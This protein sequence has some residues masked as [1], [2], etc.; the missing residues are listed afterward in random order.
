MMRFGMFLVMVSGNAAY[1]PANWR[2][3][4]ESPC[5]SRGSIWRLAIIYIVSIDLYIKYWVDD[6]HPGHLSNFVPP[7]YSSLRSF[8]E[9]HGTFLC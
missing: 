8:S 5:A 7:L 1:L 3:I 4:F 9:E 6:L 2:I